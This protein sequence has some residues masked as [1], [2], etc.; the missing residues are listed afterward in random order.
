M[1]DVLEVSRSGYYTWTTRGESARARED[2][3]LVVRIRE[4]H[5]KS[6]RSYGSPRVTKALTTPERP[7]NH[8]RIERLMRQEGIRAVHRRKYRVTT[9]SDHPHPVAEN[10]L[11]RQFT[12]PAADRTWVADLTYVWTDEGWLYLAAVMDLYSRRIV[13]WSTSERMTQELVVRALENAIRDRRPEIGLLHH[14]DRGSQY[15]SAAYQKLLGNA[16]IRC[17]MSRRGSC[18]DNAVMESFFH[19]L[20]VECVYQEGYATRQE[21]RQDLFEYI[22][23]FY[24]TWRL[25]S[26][27]GYVSPTAFEA[28]AEAVA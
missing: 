27:L 21:A 20:K 9:K 23:G 26:S 15:A 25:H 16:G 18:Y 19:T 6:R 28:Q 24:N 3:R 7:C 22:E 17:S 11:D 2:R 5:G 8:K 1:C 12:A 14:S 10:V 4:I 13:G